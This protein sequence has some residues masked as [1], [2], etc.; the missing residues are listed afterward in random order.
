MVA[1]N[2]AP[3]VLDLAGIRAGDRNLLRFVLPNPARRYRC[4]ARG[5]RRRAKSRPTPGPP[6]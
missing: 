3:A 1:V 4:R 2:L 6:R 5:R